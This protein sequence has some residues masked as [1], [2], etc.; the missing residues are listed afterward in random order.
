KKETHFCK[1]CGLGFR[2]AQAYRDHE[3]NCSKK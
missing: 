2:T 1:Y 3:A